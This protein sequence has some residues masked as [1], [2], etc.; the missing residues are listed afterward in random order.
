MAGPS[1]SS[2]CHRYRAKTVPAGNRGRTPLRALAPRPATG[3]HRA[4][5]LVMTTTAHPTEG[6]IM[7]IAA[8]GATGNLGSQ[9]A[10]DAQHRGHH[11][12]DR[13]RADVDAT[14]RAAERVLMFEVDGRSGGERRDTFQRPHDTIRRQLTAH[15][16]PRECP[17][18]S[19]PFTVNPQPHARLDRR[20][21]HH[22]F[23]NRQAHHSH[24]AKSHRQHDRRHRR[25]ACG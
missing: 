16:P 11:D 6:R 20:S 13:T 23:R 8:I 5:E 2:G 4:I 3:G 12:A 25:D 22:M 1:R 21:R 17:R 19:P 10:A 15:S 7:K 14:D 18:P 24:G 9:T